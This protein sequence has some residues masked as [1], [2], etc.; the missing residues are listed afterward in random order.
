MKLG[1]EEGQ[2]IRIVIKS[3][4]PKTVL[5]ILFFVFLYS[6]YGY[7]RIEKDFVYPVVPIAIKAY[8][9]SEA[10]FS[11]LS[12]RYEKIPWK[13]YQHHKYDKVPW[14]KWGNTDQVSYKEITKKQSRH[15]STEQK[16]STEE[17][18]NLIKNKMSDSQ[19]CR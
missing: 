18:H 2:K 13:Y 1:E 3:R 7:H 4:S 16:K 8:F 15:S 9:L 6:I 14:K 5:I 10:Y 17:L 11:E 12:E 19:K